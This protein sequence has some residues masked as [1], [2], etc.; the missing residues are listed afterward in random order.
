[1][2]SFEGSGVSWDKGLR[3]FVVS[4]VKI[5]CELC[6]W[7][8]D[9]NKIQIYKNEWT[10]WISFCSDCQLTSLDLNP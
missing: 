1:M 8:T 7:V 6:I 3:L 2:C 4:L 9:R 5:L 10:F